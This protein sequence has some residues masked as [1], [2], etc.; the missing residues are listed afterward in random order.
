M[1]RQRWGGEEKKR[2]AANNL[3]NAS[4]YATAAPVVYRLKLIFQFPH[5]E[6]WGKA[7]YLGKYPLLQGCAAV[8]LCY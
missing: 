1:K 6:K 8:G 3:R 7:V 2:F 5:T 4:E